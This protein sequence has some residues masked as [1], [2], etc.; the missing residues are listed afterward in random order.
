MMPGVLPERLRAV[1][2]ERYS[3]ERELGQGGM[4]TV[5]LAQD[6]KHHRRVAIKVLKPELAAALGSERFL[7]EIEIAA[8]LT[9]PH[10]LP[11]HDSGQADGF[12]YYTMPFVEGESLRNRLTREPQLPLEEAL[13]ITREVADALG[14]AHAL[15]LVHRD[16]KPENILF[17]AGHA[18]V[19]DFGIARAV[20]AAGNERLTG[21][22]ISVGT[23]AYMS[24]EQAVGSREVDGRSDL[25]SLGCVLYEMLS[26]EPPYTGPTA[27]AIL[28]KK[29]GEPLPRISVVRETVPASIEAALTKVLARTPADRYVTAHELL[30][31]LEPLATPS[32][33]TTPIL[34]QPPTGLGRWPR[35]VGWVAAVGGLAAVALL[36]S[37]LLISKPLNITVSDIRQVTSEPGVEFQP[38]ISPDGNEVAFVAGPIGA[39]R[40]VIRSTVDIA[41]GGEVRLGDT[42]LSS[43]WLPTWS[44]DGEFVR[45]YGCPREHDFLWLAS[46]LWRETGKLGGLTRPVM[47]PV[48]TSLLTSGAYNA[49]PSQAW[50]PEGSRVAFIVG[51]TIFTSLRGGTGIHRVAIHPTENADLHSLAWSPDAQMLAYVSGNSAWVRG[52]KVDASSIW[53]VNAEGGTPWQIVGEGFLNISPTWLDTRHLLFVSNRDG[54]RGVY[55]V[56]VGPKGRYGEPHAIPGI[57][58]PHSISYSIGAKRLAYSKFTVRQNIWSYPLGRHD[59]VPI[60][61]GEPVTTGTQVIEHHDVSPDGQW[62]VFDSN[63]RGTMGLYKMPLRGGQSIP[64]TE[65]PLD[66]F[67]P[68]WS[69]DGREIAFRTGGRSGRIMVVSADGGT[70][71]SLTSGRGL[72]SWP[73]WSPSGLRIAFQ[74]DRTGRAL[75]WI[76]ARDSVGAKWH[77]ATQLTDFRCRPSDWRA[78]DGSGVLCDTGSEAALLSL[79]GRL[80]WRRIIA[81]SDS[82]NYWDWPKY[83]RDGR[84][85]Y[86]FAIAKDGRRGIWA[87]APPGLGK[88]RL[89]I[90]SDPVAVLPGPYLSVG[91]DRLYVTVA[92]YESDI[93]VAN[94]HW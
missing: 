31:H 70:P 6:L 15:G 63:R 8:Q 34:S 53:T 72:D 77:E 1:L 46:C 33:G 83:S 35:R 80:L 66:E 48:P 54:P 23:P 39:P 32:G 89:V 69:P 82:I 43:E 26:G 84:T 45:F 19:A 47:V 4:A 90:S 57:A 50:S 93:W 2:A 5:Y 68:R 52:G 94:L 9:H 42:A 79:Q 21:T 37:R 3:I 64:L 28:A 59:P 20:S 11:L 51:D 7:R 29:L 58:D 67:E 92:E 65:S 44:P 16:I 75:L 30:T 13:Q 74:S 76:L 60:S 73:V 71:V 86:F 91:L 55:V 61:L 10:I 88:P 78:T 85:I 25:Y 81:G 17:E 87:L 62:I 49:V 22:G 27:Q 56:E 41:G 36:V 38:A 14:Y 24:P 12:L 18:V 40:L